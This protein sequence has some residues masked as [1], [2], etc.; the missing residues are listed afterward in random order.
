MITF[1]SFQ[2]KVETLPAFIS[3]K[4]GK[5]SYTN[6]KLDGRSLSFDR[7]NTQKKWEFDIRT[8][9]DIYK[10]HKFI[11]TSVIKQETNGRTNSPMVA[12]LMVIG[13]LDGKGYR[14]GKR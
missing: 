9:Y 2:Y 11:N 13:C 1:K 3:S 4:T 8:L 5:A 10:K 12:V 7:V 6:L 14:T